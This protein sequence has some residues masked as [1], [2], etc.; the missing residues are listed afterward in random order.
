MLSMLLLKNQQPT[1]QASAKRAGQEWQPHDAAGRIIKRHLAVQ[2]AKARHASWALQQQGTALPPAALL[3]RQH[4]SAPAPLAPWCYYKG[5]SWEGSPAPPHR[6]H[7]A[8]PASPRLS[9]SHRRH[10]WTHAPACASNKGEL[11]RRARLH[12]SA[13]LWQTSL[14]APC[15]GR[16]IHS[17]KHARCT[18][19]AKQLQSAAARFGDVPPSAR[20]AARLGLGV[21]ASTSGPLQAQVFSKGLARTPTFL[22][23][24]R[25][26]QPAHWQCPPSYRA[27]NLDSNQRELPWR[28]SGIPARIPA[29]TLPG[30]LACAA[31]GVGLCG[32]RRGTQAGNRS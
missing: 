17:N 12:C 28:R 18:A 4:R 14:A 7:P 30:C 13:A 8:V 23:Q 26:Q 19:G 15:R 2:Q 1:P 22:R 21:P 32:G 29:R 16:V 20:Q 6:F 9:P 11:Q 5:P 24:Q 31:R 27:Q 25:W 3:H 10:Q